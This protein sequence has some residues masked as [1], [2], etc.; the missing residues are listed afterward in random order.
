MLCGRTNLWG[1][2]VLR[3]FPRDLSIDQLCRALSWI[4]EGNRRLGNL[5]WQLPRLISNAEL[6]PPRLEALRD[7]LINLLSAGLCW[8]NEWP[9]IVC[10][11]LHLSGA[12]AATSVRGLDDSKSDSWL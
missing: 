3:L 6:D 8:Q 10:D 7:G 12:L 5:N 4:K 1:D 11:R 9:H 2:V